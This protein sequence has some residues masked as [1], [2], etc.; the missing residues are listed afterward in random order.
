MPNFLTTS[1]HDLTH[2]S[3]AYP[4]T[5]TEAQGSTCPS[6]CLWHPRGHTPC[7]RDFVQAMNRSSSS[8]VSPD[9]P[10]ARCEHGVVNAVVAGAA[11]ATE[12]LR[13]LLFAQIQCVPLHLNICFLLELRHD[14]ASSAQTMLCIASLL[15]NCVTD[16]KRHACCLAT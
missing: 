12:I 8:T 16:Y 4:M 3:L 7:T 9:D 10:C 11:S 15:G 5:N 13:L 2:A 6:Y 14:L 1:R